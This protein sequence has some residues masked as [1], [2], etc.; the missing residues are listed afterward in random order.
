MF[1]SSCYQH[2]VSRRRVC[3][4]SRLLL[5]ALLLTMS[6]GCSRKG[7]LLESAQASWDGGDF[8][9][10]VEQYEE[11]L[12]DNPHHGRAPEARLRVAS[13]YYYNLKSYEKAI[14]HY[15]HLIE[16]FPKSPDV[17][18]ARIRLAECYVALGKRQEAINE[19]EALL[20]APGGEVD[21]RRVRLGIA[22][23]Y[24]ELND[25]GQALAEYEKVS[26]VAAYDQL[27]ERAL[28]RIAGIRFLRDEFTEALAAYDQIARNSNDR[29][30]I[31][32]ARLGVADCYTRTF[33]YDL[34]VKTLEQTE[35]EP[36]SPEDLKHRIAAIREE[37][38]LRNFSLT[39]TTRP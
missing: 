3:P 34:A 14:Q 27:S 20:N 1:R 21:R 11:F 9:R 28:L 6:A 7:E 38:R 16:D 5:L 4:L 39:Q 36:S 23:L 22:D 25:L 2:A 29:T 37:Q 13:I 15:I 31:R 26:T 18:S 35:P 24:Y 8:V 12:R 30:V 17:G 10:A 19:Y 33:N 32:Q